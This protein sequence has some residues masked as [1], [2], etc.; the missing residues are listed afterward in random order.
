MPLKLSSLNTTN[1][2]PL[3]G[4]I[5]QDSNT[6]VRHH[7][8]GKRWVQQPN[9]LPNNPFD[10]QISDNTITRAKISPEIVKDLS[11]SA[12]RDLAVAATEELEDRGL[13]RACPKCETIG[14]SFE[15]GDYICKRCRFG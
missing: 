15:E 10:T 7:Y 13:D 5:Y 1:A 12:L 2:G 8:D 6:N 4:Q 9:I 3:P 11:D 14:G